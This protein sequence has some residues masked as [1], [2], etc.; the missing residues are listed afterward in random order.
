MRT[1]LTL[2]ERPDHQLYCKDARGDVWLHRT[3]GAVNREPSAWR[4]W[5]LLDCADRDFSGFVRLRDGF[6]VCLVCALI[7]DTAMR[8]AGACARHDDPGDFGLTRDGLKY[9][10]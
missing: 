10:A 7:D 8:G 2:H 9:D 3:M 4:T 6:R 1:H 5:P